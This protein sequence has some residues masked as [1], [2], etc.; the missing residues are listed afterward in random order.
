MTDKILTVNN[1]TIKYE[2]KAE[3]AV[4]NLSFSLEKGETVGLFGKSGCG[5][6]SVAWTIMGRIDNMGGRAAGEIVF[7]NVNL[8]AIED[9]T[10]HDI[11]WKKLAIVPQSSMNALNPVYKIK[12]TLMETMTRYMPTCSLVEMEK[13]CEELID[14]VYLDYRV[15]HCYPHELSGGMQQRVFIALATMLNPDLLILDEATTGLDVIVEANILQTLMRIK[16][17]KN[18]T[19]LFISHDARIHD[20]FC[21]RRINL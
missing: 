10:W 4:E 6:S 20:A 8:L 2:N 7:E 5:K 9:K 1:L 17:E 11:R 16:Q 13:K 12:K 21:D 18:M 19:M 15:L 3:P 14:M